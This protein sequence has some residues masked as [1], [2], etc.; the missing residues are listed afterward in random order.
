[1][2]NNPSFSL[3]DTPYTAYSGADMHAMIHNRE[4]GNLQ[5]VTI[6]ISRE[7]AALYA[8]G[9]PNAKTF[10]KGKRAI[11]GTLVFSQFDRHALLHSSFAEAFNGQFKD[12]VKNLSGAGLS[13]D[14]LWRNQIN[15]HGFSG[16]SVGDTEIPGGSGATLAVTNEMAAV[17]RRIGEQRLRY[18]DQ[19][20]PFDVTI[21]LV[22]DSGDASF[23]AIEG[24][25]LIN[26]SSAFTIDNLNSDQAFT[27][28]ARAVI[29]LVNLT[30]RTLWKPMG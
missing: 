9:D 5:A 29:P 12:T 25:V 22:N 6:Q 15:V 28:I 2:P 20:P 7:V 16:V 17:Y 18:T 27:Y 21:C 19:I 11:A 10:V 23:C 1:M 3:D 24:V 30:D 13:P 4:V 26:E 8:C 14:D